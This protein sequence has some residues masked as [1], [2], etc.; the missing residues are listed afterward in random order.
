[1][2]FFQYS[3]HNVPTFASGHVRR[4]TILRGLR[5]PLLWCLLPTRFIAHGTALGSLILRAPKVSRMSGALY[6][7]ILISCRL[8]DDNQPVGDR[9]QAGR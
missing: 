9:L 3:S 1:M 5:F 8:I 7:M 4:T 2:T 6:K